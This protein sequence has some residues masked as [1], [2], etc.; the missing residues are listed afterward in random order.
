MM[1]EKPWL[2]IRE[3]YLKIRRELRCAGRMLE[4]IALPMVG[5]STMVAPHANVS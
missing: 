5:R 3:G 2:A 1:I 4:K